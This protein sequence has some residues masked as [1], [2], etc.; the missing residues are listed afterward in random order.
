[1]QAALTI[2]VVMVLVLGIVLGFVHR[3][4]RLGWISMALGTVLAVAIAVGMGGGI[5]AGFAGL[6]GVILLLIAGATPTY[7]LAAG[8]GGPP[9]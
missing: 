9:Q 7:A 8:M 2:A 1:M 3:D 6:I 5:T 4:G